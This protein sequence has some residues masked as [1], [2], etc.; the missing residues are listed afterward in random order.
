MT[1]KTRKSKKVI[2][3]VKSIKPKLDTTSK[4][5]R[6]DKN[7]FDSDDESKFEVSSMDIKCFEK[8][9]WKHVVLNLKVKKISL[10]L[11][12]YAM[13]VLSASHPRIT[14]NTHKSP[15]NSLRF[16]R[17]I[18]WKFL[19]ICWINFVRFSAFKLKTS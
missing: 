1:K 14:K 7:I 4:K 3:A 8:R 18:C 19:R 5:L 13:K 17:T 15:F 11:F 16:T 2:K 12:E 9:Y 10:M 6:L